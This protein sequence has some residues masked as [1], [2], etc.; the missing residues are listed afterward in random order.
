MRTYISGTTQ[1]KKLPFCNYVEVWLFEV[2]CSSVCIRENGAKFEGLMEG[3]L[4]IV[5]CMHSV[6]VRFFPNIQR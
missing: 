3:E 4:G 6:G 5:L 2:I 1:V